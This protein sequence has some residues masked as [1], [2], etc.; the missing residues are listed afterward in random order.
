MA[1]GGIPDTP[2][3]TQGVALAELADGGKLARARRRAR[4]CSL[5]RRG[6]GDL[7]RRRA[8][9]PLRGRSPKG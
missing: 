4:R 5:V 8:L 3:L 9:H 7:R 2:D 6:D 1:S